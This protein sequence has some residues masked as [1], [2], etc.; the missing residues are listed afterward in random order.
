MNMRKP[1]LLGALFLSLVMCRD[2]DDD[3]DM[4]GGGNPP[5]GSIVCSSSMPI[6]SDYDLGLP[7][8]APQTF[9]PDDN[10]MKTASVE[11]GRFLFWE[12]KL[13]GDNTMSCGT[14]HAPSSAFSD[15]SPTSEGIDGNFGTRNTMAIVNLVFQPI[16]RWD[17]GQPDLEGQAAGPV[18][19][20]IEM[21]DDWDD[22]VLELESD[23][24]YPPMFE[25]A[26]GSP[27][28]DK[29]RAAKAMAQF[30]RSMISFDAKFDRVI[31]G[32]ESFTPLEQLGLEIWDLEGGSPP[33]VPIGQEGADCFHCHQ[34]SNYLFTD[35][36]FHN[37]GLDSVFTDLGQGGITN[38]PS[39]Y[40]RFKVPTLR[41]IEY[42]APYM[43]DGRFQTLEQVV[44]HYDSGGHP[45]TTVDPFMKFTVGG[46]QLTAE[47]KAAL[48]AFMKTL[49]DP[50]FLT[51]PDFQDPF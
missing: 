32:P 21:H 10:P 16:I 23:T 33:L 12:K 45:S 17:G 42:S 13:S 36:Q 1:F 50:D 43:H 31:F 40:G 44:D 26:Y 29:T 49:S 19:N 14:C 7:F 34:V 47:K 37:N 28:I 35:N 20:P 27:C 24:L 25:A 2:K 22:V 5:S 9:I 46:L 38:N 8:Y 6:G 51:N 39:H 11:L 18:E 4:M 48:V 30:M 15:P 41:N 3:D